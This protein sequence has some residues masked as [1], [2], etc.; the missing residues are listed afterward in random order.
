MKL[1]LTALVMVLISAMLVSVIFPGDQ[2]VFGVEKIWVIIALAGLLIFISS[3]IDTANYP[4]FLFIFSNLQFLA[5][6]FSKRAR[7]GF[8]EV[9]KP[10]KKITYNWKVR[11]RD[12]IDTGREIIFK[13]LPLRGL[14]PDIKGLSM[15]LTGATRVLYSSRN[16]VLKLQTG[17][18]EKLEPQEAVVNKKLNIEVGHGE[19]KF[20]IKKG[21]YHVIYLPKANIK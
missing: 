16:K 3:K 6:K 9:S 14:A 5:S 11:Y 13:D 1:A 21:D 15:K 20:V 2:K 4:F 8:T 17:K 18:F 19:V 12:V 10:R 7:V